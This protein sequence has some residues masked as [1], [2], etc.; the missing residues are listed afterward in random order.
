MEQATVDRNRAQQAD[1]YGEPVGDTVRRLLPALGLSQGQLAGLV[2]LSAPM[3]SQLATGQRAKIANPA[4]LTRLQ[5]LSSLADDP[6]LPDLSRSELARRTAAVRDL[7]PTGVLTTTHASPSPAGGAAAVQAL[8]RAV[9]SA[10]E[11]QRAA[12]LLQGRHPALAEVL[13]VYGLGRTAD[14][15]AHYAAMVET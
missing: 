15:R 3:L 1:W 4:V 9:A 13:R 7:E 11:V 5:A 12:A 6:G 10:D 14:A 2:G 8:L